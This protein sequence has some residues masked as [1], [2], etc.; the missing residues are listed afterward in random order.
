MKA[1]RLTIPGML[2]ITLEKHGDERGFFMEVFRDDVFRTAG[3]N[4]NFVQD[5][6]SL[7]GKHI[8]RGMHYRV[9]TPEGKL[10]SVLRGKI[11][12]V[13]VDL[14]R[15]SPT[16]GQWCGVTLSADV[17]QQLYLPPGI[18]HGFCTLE[19]ENELYYQCT[20]YYN[21]EDEGGLLWCD[22]Q[23][24][25]VWPIDKPATSKRDSH[26]PLLKNIANCRLPKI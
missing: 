15:D 23:I 16:F 22:P 4:N 26:F 14:R 2:I 9:N 12:D 5:N 3:I 7:S 10:V 11:F 20:D 21:S 19:D 8:L 13:G 24:G 1:E 18:A 6:R 17:P 25:I